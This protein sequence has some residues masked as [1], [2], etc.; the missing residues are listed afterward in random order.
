VT[1]YVDT[2]IVIYFIEQN[3]AWF[4][5]VIARF[6]RLR[7][8]KDQLALGDLTRAECLVGPFRSGDTAVE[9][10]YRAFFGDPEIQ[11]L[12]VTAP[13]CERA[14]HIRA[15]Q[16]FRMIDAL[17]LATALEHGCGLFLTNDVRLARCTAISVEVLT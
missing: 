15:V 10:S 5:K 7:A 9:A 3:P 14:A 2:N 4:A 12:P 1:V 11:V 13:I 8:A 17:H 16:N 6:A